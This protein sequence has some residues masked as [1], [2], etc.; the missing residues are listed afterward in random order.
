MA[1]RR[2]GLAARARR[3][4]AGCGG[5]AQHWAP[6]RERV[7]GPGRA[8]RR[9]T[10]ARPTS[11]RCA[12]SAPISPISKRATARSARDPALRRQLGASAQ[13]AGCTFGAVHAYDPCVA[14]RA[15]GGQFRHHRAARRNAAA[16]GDRA[17]QAGRRLPD[18]VSEAAVESELTTFLNQVEGHVGQPAVLKIAPAFE[19]RYHIAG[20]IERNLWLERDWLAARLRRAAVDL[21]DRQLARYAPRRGDEPR[22]LG[23]AA[24]LTAEPALT[25]LRITRFRRS[26]TCSPRRH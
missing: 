21:V 13:A 20:R 23:S 10:T 15:P 4:A 5:S 16:A 26:P 9:A 12:R 11:R 24:A 18:P 19:E 17:R 8:D 25:G 3:A 2:A 6:P 14:G 22:A 7:P 1:P